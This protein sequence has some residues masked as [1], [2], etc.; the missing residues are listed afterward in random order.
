MQIDFHHATTYVVARLA[1]FAPA[2][3][4]IVAHSAQYVDDAT[5]S[6]E[7]YF[8]NGGIYERIS[9]A[10]KLYDYRNMGSLSD[11][12][13]WVPFHFLPGNRA[14][15]QPKSPPDLDREEFLERCITRPN[16]HTAREMMKA[17]VLRQNRP[18]ALHRLGIAAHVFADTWAHQGFVGLRDRINL[19]TEIDANDAHHEKT[20][21]E[22]F[23][24]FFGHGIEVAEEKFIGESLPLGHG[25]VLSYPDRPYLVWSYR[26]GHGELVQRNNPREFTEAAANLY[27]W[28]RRYLDQ[29]KRR[30]EVLTTEY[31]LPAEFSAIE[32]MLAETNNE[33]KLDRHQVWLRAVG[34]GTFGFSDALTYIESGPGSWREQALGTS[35]DIESSE[36]HPIDCPPAFFTSHWKFFHDALEAHRFFVLNEML[37]AYGI[38]ST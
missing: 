7:I 32:K 38:L 11:H 12:H 4:E 23:R 8:D 22:R 18:Y 34:D 36:D 5:S 19:A 25:V 27:Q 17:V 20:F 35:E 24:E 10:H 30:R 16:S 14:E 9:S 21:G 15:P 31:P 1:G 3:A 37:P 29:P 26:N 28:F 13:V 33:K 2:E 6:G